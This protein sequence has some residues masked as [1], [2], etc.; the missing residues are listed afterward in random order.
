[1]EGT[2]KKNMGPPDRL[3]ITTSRMS[4]T[5]WITKATNTHS[6]YV[7]VTTFPLQQLL[8]ERA[9][10]LSYK[11]FTYLVIC[12]VHKLQTHSSTV[13][14][15]R[16]LFAGFSPRLFIHSRANLCETCGGQSGTV[17][18]FCPNAF[19]HPVSIIPLHSYI[20]HQSYL[21]LAIDSIVTC[22]VW[23]KETCPVTPQ[24]ECK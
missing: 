5:C 7:I 9:S 1:M 23:K 4:F 12:N 21:D 2:K 10:M 14:W 15:F 19:I 22:R 8:H 17:T 6:E 16:Q 3:Q 11:Y 18:G 20:Y 24:N 13:P